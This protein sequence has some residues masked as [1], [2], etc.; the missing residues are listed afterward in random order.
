MSVPPKP[1]LHA[2]LSKLSYL[3]GKWRGQ[4]HGTRQ[5]ATHPRTS[6]SPPQQ[7]HSRALPPP[8]MHARAHMP[9]LQIHRLT[10]TRSTHHT[11]T[12]T[13]SQGSMQ[14]SRTLT[15]GKRLRLHTLAD[16]SLCTSM[17]SFLI[18]THSTIIAR[19]SSHLQP[20]P[21][22]PLPKYL[23]AETNTC[24]FFPLLIASSFRFRFCFS[25]FL[26]F[27][28]VKKHGTPKQTHLC[29]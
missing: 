17:L 10:L 2:N 28:T 23:N 11:H 14:P 15:M 16:R 3:V 7:A 12:R 18:S 26:V 22:S 19:F 1:E 24:T 8:L 29:M 4:G 9:S 20:R 13:R 21:F 25:S 6:L 27:L 5:T